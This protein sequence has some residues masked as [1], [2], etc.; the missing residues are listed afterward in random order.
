MKSGAMYAVI[1]G[2]W[3]L[4]L[5]YFDPPLAALLIGP[6]PLLAKLGVGGLILG[7]NLFW[8]Y[9]WYHLVIV[10]YSYL[11][12]RSTPPPFLLNVPSCGVPK[13]ALLY[14]T[15][16]DFQEEAARTHL[17]QD[18]PDFHLF[19]LDDG[20]VPAYCQRVDA[21]ARQ[22][23]DRVSVIRRVS[24]TGF[25]AGNVNHALRLISD[26]YAYFSISDADTILPPN[27][28]RAL[29][30]PI[31]NPRIAFAQATQR[32]NPRQPTPFARIMAFHTDLHYRHYAS[33]KNRFGFV[34]FY[35]HGALMR[36]DVWKI[37]GGFPEI[38]TEDLAYAIKAR[39]AGYE[40]VLVEDVVCLE[41]FPPTYRQYRK[42]N[43]KWIR[44]TT[45]CL[46]EGFPTMW[47]ARHI[48]WFEKLDVVASGLSLLLALP[49]VLLLLLVSLLL[50]LWFTC[51]RFQGPMLRM[52]MMIEKT[53]LAIATQVQGNLFLNW[54]GYG[55]VLT[56]VCAPM[57]PIVIDFARRPA[58]LLRSLATFSFQC[59]ALQIASATHALSYLM[60]QTSVFPVTGDVTED[61]ARRERGVEPRRGLANWLAESHANRRALVL[62]ELVC[63]AIFWGLGIAT[64]NIWL[65]PLAIAL[66]LSPM[67]LR[68][69]LDPTPLRLAIWAPFVLTLSIVGMV[70]RNLIAP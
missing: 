33:T 5:L 29:L 27:Y 67:V 58:T 48:P 21:F 12:P 61:R 57:L 40:G 19:L 52:P 31:A 55:L 11:A 28:L 23:P 2:L 42:R 49:F 38:A 34:M 60:T 46:V 54:P 22:H 32:A 6:E 43:E 26:Q 16:N 4:C 56:A 7:L 9:A 53:W 13:V 59:C 24:R 30:P 44:G 65:F 70:A 35:G 14:T 50:P 36:M 51:F 17:Q 41:E 3:A 66:G 69:N 1:L 39:A 25:K 15:C 10:G 47:K 45:E 62:G 20:T 37:L 8:F 63:A 68:W 64:Q 18:Y